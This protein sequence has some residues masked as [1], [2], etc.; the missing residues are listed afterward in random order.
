M[1]L[2]RCDFHMQHRVFGSHKLSFSQ[3]SNEDLHMTSV[4]QW[5]LS[6]C[7][8]ALSST[9]MAHGVTCG[10]IQVAHPHS[11]PT[12][13]VGKVGAVYFN[14]ITNKGAQADQ[15]VAASTPVSP[16]VEIHEMAMSGDV[17]KMRAVS[18][19]DLPPGKEVVLKRGQANGYHVMLM[20]LGKPLK[21]GDK[22]PITLTFKRAGACQAEVVVAAPKAAEA[23]QH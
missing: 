6:A 18:A 2:L 19:V 21:A 23:H 12:I 16:M 22:F 14:G 10:D 9:A 1:F 8:L 15:L 11:P 17:M 20:D 3:Q 13:G 5:L 7:A 4:K